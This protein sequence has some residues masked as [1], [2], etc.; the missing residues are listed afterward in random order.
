[1]TARVESGALLVRDIMTADPISVPPETSIVDARRLMDETHIRHLLVTR[2][3]ELLGIV[4][5]RDVR[6][7]MP[8]NAT[9]LSAWELNYLLNK[10]P[11]AEVM[12]RTVITVGPARTAV[13]AARLLLDH[14]IGALPVVDEGRRVGIVTET[15]LL[16]AFVRSAWGA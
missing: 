16:R 3:G 11:V 10:L 4:T 1:V 8:S 2:A 9:S 5:D 14:K 15:D 13:E 7:A 12:T 6:L